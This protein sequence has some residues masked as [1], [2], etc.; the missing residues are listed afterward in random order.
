MNLT[1]I[2]QT[3]SKLF[4]FGLLGGVY[5]LQFYGLWL[6]PFMD[7][8]FP[9]PWDVYFVRSV[10]TVISLSLIWLVAPSVFR[11]FSFKFRPKTFWIGFAFTVIATIPNIYYFGIDYQG[12]GNLAAGFCFALAIGIDEEIYD[13]GFSFGAL[14]RFGMEFA[15]VVSAVLF[16]LSHFTNYLYGDE[17]FEYVLGHMVD[18]ATFGYLMAALMLMTGNIWL[19]ILVHGLIDLPWVMMPEKE[20]SDAI[21]AGTD[22]FSVL[23]YAL[24]NIL[25]A[26]VMIFYMRGNFRNIN[27]PSRLQRVAK[28]LGLIE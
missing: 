17:S 2:R 24:T 12:F 4:I 14:E 21:S 10:Q 27:W 1:W 19:P 13:R 18:A 8:N 25:V 23:G 6:L 22:W 11:R 7:V 15:L 3:Q 5:L 26:R 9:H 20:Y 16:G 28:F